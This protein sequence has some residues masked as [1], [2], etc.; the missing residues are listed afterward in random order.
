MGSTWPIVVVMCLLTACSQV[1]AEDL[2]ALKADPMATLEISGATLVRTSESE[3]EVGLMAKPSLARI[4]NY[5]RVSG[6]D[7]SAVKLEAVKR[8]EEGGWKL[9]N[10]NARVVVGSKD[11]VTGHAEIGIYFVEQNGEQLLLVLLTHAFD[12]PH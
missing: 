4:F 9:A 1:F 7:R 3:A 12:H 11:L 2:R 6:D 5:Y 10:P 8:A